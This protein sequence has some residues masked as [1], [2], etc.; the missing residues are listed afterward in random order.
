MNIKNMLKNFI[1]GTDD[2]YIESDDA[3]FEDDFDFA[4]S[5][6][7]EEP[8]EKSQ[9]KAKFNISKNEKAQASNVV[10]LAS[11]KP[12]AS[13]PKPHVVFQKIDRF[14]E[15]AAVADVLNQ[16]RIVILNLETCPN[17]V[18]QR[19]IDFLYGVAYANHG[20]FKKVAG[21]AYIIT[22][23]NVPVS[24]ELIDE[25]AGMGEAEEY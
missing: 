8:A 23:N 2:N 24:G 17:D 21:R 5:S 3:N 9:P 12:A 11:S 15:V 10:N 22:P 14:E 4:P 7:V 18:S 20:E 16:K 6:A 13:T 1:N 19:I 25:L